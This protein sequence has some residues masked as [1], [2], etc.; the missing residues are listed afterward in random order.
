MSDQEGSTPP[1][2]PSGPPSDPPA[3]PPA[4][5][6]PPPSDPP[7]P[8]SDSGSVSENR[9]LMIVLAYMWILALIPLLV[10]KNDKEVQWHAK[11]G[12][13]LAVGEFGLWIVLTILNSFVVFLGCFIMP[14]IWLGLVVLHILCA[15]KGAKGERLIIPGVSQYADKWEM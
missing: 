9:T 10:E 15:V 4:A 13:V 11:H 5:P 6:P 7:P 1:S 8:S 2:P 12:L 3:P 14:L